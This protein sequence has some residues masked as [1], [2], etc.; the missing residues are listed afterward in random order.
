MDS[1]RLISGSGATLN[2]MPWVSSE[3]L[4][5]SDSGSNKDTISWNQL[6][7]GIRPEAISPS[8]PDGTDACTIFRLK[9]FWDSIG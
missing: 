8:V 6:P 3:S 9:K 4:S 1:L 5:T 7:D 2:R